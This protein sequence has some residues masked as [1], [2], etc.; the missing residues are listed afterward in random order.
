MSEVL[1]SATNREN[2]GKGPA[3]RLRREG[4]VPCTLYGIEKNT[5]ACT[6]NRREL[7]K[8]LAEAHSVIVLNF[9]GKEQQTV[10]REIQYHPVKGTVIHVDFQRLKAGQEIT[11]DVP[12]HFIGEAIG[13]KAGGVFQEA[14]SELN[15]TCMPKDL[16]DSIKIDVSNL[17]V[18]EAVHVR[19]LKLENV[20]INDDESLTIC[21]IQVSRKA[22]S[23]MEETAEVESEESMEPEVITRS[24]KDEEGE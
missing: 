23:E 7:E 13:I 10:I 4:L 22:T 8:V 21:S 24:K 3:N 19:D 9:D 20:T 11:V 15:I 5:T 14:R 16:P 12:I 1:L 6:V 2:T 17:Q 18:G